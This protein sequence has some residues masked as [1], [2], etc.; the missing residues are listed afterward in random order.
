MTEEDG[1]EN[2]VYSVTKMWEPSKASWKEWKP[3]SSWEKGDEETEDFMSIPAGGGDFDSATVVKESKDSDAY[4]ESFDVT[5]MLKKMIS[6]TNNGFLFDYGMYDP[7]A[8][9][10]DYHSSQAGNQDDRPKLVVEFEETGIVSPKSIQNAGIVQLSSLGKN[11]TVTVGRTGNYNAE[12]CDL[13]GKVF[14]SVELQGSR[15]QQIGDESLAVGIYVI[16]ITGDNLVYAQKIVV[17]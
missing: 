8:A 16:R 3:G 14:S 12:L 11:I 6:G 9:G 10:R 5:T 17:K 7:T 1:L 13:Q 2:N 4:W 15:S